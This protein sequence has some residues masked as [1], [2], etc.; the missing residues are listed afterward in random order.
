MAEILIV[1]DDQSI[2]SAFERFL[3]LEGHE[4]RLASNAADAIR[5]VGEREPHLV[6]MDVRMP[7][8]DGLQALAQ[9]KRL[10]PSLQ[11]VIMTAHGTSQ[12]SIDAM[13]AGA[14]EYVTK[15]FD[16]DKLRSVIAR[17]LAS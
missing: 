9:M 8:T 6:M 7:G 2:A 3:R 10:R 13:R 15:P 4:C 5:L 16:L 12:T 17:V 11:V 14:F 1:D